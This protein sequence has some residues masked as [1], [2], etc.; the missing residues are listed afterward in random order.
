LTIFLPRLGKGEDLP[1]CESAF[2]YKLVL[3]EFACISY[4]IFVMMEK[5]KLE[6]KYKCILIVT[7]N[8]KSLVINAFF[9]IFFRRFKLHIWSKKHTEVS[10]QEENLFNKMLL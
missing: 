4:F 5:K 6:L 1:N 2:L 7:G 8:Y 10:R 3:H 9:K